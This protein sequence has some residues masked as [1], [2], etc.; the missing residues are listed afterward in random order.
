MRSRRIL[1]VPALIYALAALWR[2]VWVPCLDVRAL[3]IGWHPA[4]QTPVTLPLWRI[5]AEQVRYGLVA[6][7]EMVLLSGF[8][9][10]CALLW[11][12]GTLKASN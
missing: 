11:A 5:G 8:A 10:V 9:A 7:E 4:V 12:T 1:A 6:F 3:A 2:M